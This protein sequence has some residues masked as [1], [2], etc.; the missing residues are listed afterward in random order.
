MAEKNRRAEEMVEAPTAPVEGHKI[1]DLLNELALQKSE[2]LKLHHENESC[3]NYFESLYQKYFTFFDFAPIGFLT[4]DRDG[5]IREINL[6]AATALGLPR[7]ALAGR[8][9]TGF[10]HPEDQGVFYYQKLLCMEKPEGSTFELKIRSGQGAFFDARLQ[11]LVLPESCWPASVFILSLRNISDRQHLADSLLLTRRWLETTLRVTDPDVLQRD[12]VEQLKDYLQ[13]DAVGICQTS[14]SGMP[15]TWVQEG[16]DQAFLQSFSPL[17]YKDRPGTTDP[18]MGPGADAGQ[19]LF[20]TPEGSFYT[21][22]ASRRQAGERVRGPAEAVA[23]CRSQGFESAAFIPVR[24]GVSKCMVIAAADRSQYRFPLRMVE[25]IELVAQ[26]LGLALQRLKLRQD[27]QAS[28]DAFKAL[29]G[30]ILTVQE[31]EQRRIAMELHDGC[32]Q[33]LILLKLRLQGMRGLVP[34]GGAEL[35]AVLGTLI[36]DCDKVI[37][38]LREICYEL[39]P[40]D[41]RAMG[42]AG[43]MRQLAQDFSAASGL[44]V[45][46]RVDPLDRVTDPRVQTGLFRVLQEALSNVRKHSRATWVHL[47]VHRRREGLEICIEDNG[48]GFEVRSGRTRGNGRQGMGLPAM[49]LRCQ[50]VG[51]ALSIDSQA[52]KGTRILIR[53]DC[54]KETADR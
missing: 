21:N 12:C 48:T 1:K 32:G 15:P 54:G 5:Y 38:N 6:A 39:Q 30:H 16:F 52:G 9:I 29:S 43:A 23:T 33:D 4:L 45:E 24:A 2:L 40:A 31:E 46:A 20:F 51:A 34:A 35:P 19:N 53:L 8:R 36:A 44:V 27:L 37:R 26:R 25:T 10:I 42:L 17:P 11:M 22:T 49:E 47:D 41:I 3:R 14:G 18:A 13:C 50:M 7:G 28:L